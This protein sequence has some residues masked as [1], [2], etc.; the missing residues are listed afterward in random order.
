MTF[1]PAIAA[2][3]LAVLSTTANAQSRVAMPDPFAGL[4]PSEKKDLTEQA[5]SFFRAAKP[6]VATAAKST[7]TLSYRGQRLCY[8]TVV[9]ATGTEHPAILTKWSEIRNV[10][11]RLAV[12]T[13]AGDTFPATVIGVYPR[14]D[15]AVLTAGARGAKLVPLDLSRSPSPA[16]GSFLVLPTPD[17]RAKHFG[18]VSVGERSLREKD[19]AYLGVV[20]DFAR[21]G[22]NGVPLREVM[23][24]SAA[25]RAGLRGG[26]VI[27]TVGQTPVTAAMEMRNLLQRQEPGSPVTI[28]YR[29]GGR[30]KS[31]T[32]RLGTRPEMAGIRRVSP[33][34]MRRMERM[35]TVPS[36]VR[37]NFPS[38]IQTDMPITPRDAGAPVTDLDGNT[39]GIAIA[40]GSR[41][42]TYI[43]P[44]AT[45][46][47]IL[48]G[49]AN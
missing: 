4:T 12:T 13:P 40:R 9:A 39:V 25:D 8:G 18:V 36:H 23:A 37:T 41:I 7:V 26:D 47:S 17:G 1:H 29:R 32:V 30:E 22:K 48:S 24:G 5:A 19:K 16:P 34:R 20:M 49:T 46:R 42:K 35:G 3:G 27:T 31:A 15:L 43:I 28:R 10:R 6:A 21:A 14:H 33:E 2:L 45:V 44:A 11:H 38:V